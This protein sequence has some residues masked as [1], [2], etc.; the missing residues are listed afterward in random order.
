GTVVKGAHPEWPLSAA[1]TTTT[2]IKPPLPPPSAA[3]ATAL[4]TPVAHPL[5]HTTFYKALH[6]SSLNLNHTLFPLNTT[7]NLTP[8]TFPLKTTTSTTNPN[9]EPTPPFPPSSTASNPSN[10]LSTT[11][12]ITLSATPPLASRTLTHL[13]HLASIKST[14]NTLKSSLSNHTHVDFAA[15]SLKAMN[16]L[17]ELDSIQDC[18]PMIVDGKRSVSRDL[19]RFLDSIEEVALKR[20][21]LYVRAAKTVKSGKKVHKPR[22]SGDD[23]KRKLLQNLRARVEKLSKLCEVSANDEEDS[24]PEEGI[25]DGVTNVLIGGRDGVSP[26]K[27]GVFLHRQEVQPGV[28]KSVR[29]AENG[30]ICEFYSGDVTCSDGSCSSSDEQGEVLE[31]VSGAVEDDG[32]DSSQGAE[33]DEEVLVVDSGGSPHS[34]GDGERNK[35]GRNVVN[36]QLQAH[37]ERLLFSAPLPLKMENRSDL[38]KSK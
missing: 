22:N 35:R 20:H 19:V 10:P 27:N 7:P 17:L 21:V 11:T 8:T 28:K 26:S 36:E 30:N 33:D 14:L 9:I 16:L 2:T 37:Q 13:K 6:H 15:L 29:F 23:E 4:L 32:V 24:E 12:P 25:H 38:K 18:D 34:S 5:H 31:N 3:A 1:T